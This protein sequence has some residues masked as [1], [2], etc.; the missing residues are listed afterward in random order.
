MSKQLELK[1][2][3]QQIESLPTF[4]SL[5][6]MQGLSVVLAQINAATLSIEQR[7]SLLTCVD[8]VVEGL[9]SFYQEAIRHHAFPLPVKPRAL[10]ATFQSLLGDAIS[11][12]KKLIQELIQRYDEDIPEDILHE[13]ILRSVNYLSQ[14]ALQSYAVY[15]PVPNTVWQDLHRLF[16][17]SEQKQLLTKRVEHLSD[18]SVSGAYARV[19]LMELADPGH[20]MQ[21]E[22]YQAY[23]YLR[24]WALAVRFEHP[25]E[26]PPVPLNELIINRFFCDLGSDSPPD[27][28]IEEI[29]RIPADARLLRLDEL[30][31]IV[32][33]RI[34]SLAEATER[35]LT[36]RLETELLERLLAAWKQR[37][38]RCQLRQIR[39]GITVKVI[40]GLSACHY[41]FSGYEPFEPEQVEVSLHG[42]SY[43]R[44]DSLSLVE[45]DEQPWLQSDAEAK[46]KSGVI[47]PRSLGFDLENTEND[48]WKKANI[49][50]SKQET[51][52]ERSI[53]Q[54]SHGRVH[55][56]SLVNTSSGGEG[57]ESVSG[58]DVRL[59]VGEL[60]AAFPYDNDDD[61]PKLHV[62]RWIRCE[63]GEKLS[64]GLR[65]IEGDCKPVA[66]R[67]IDSQARYLEYARAFL[68]GDES[69]L[70][71]P[72]G[73]Y[74]TN[75]ILVVNDG[76]Q[77][78]LFSLYSL[79]EHTRVFSR[80]G[81]K[82]IASTEQNASSITASL[83]QL[84]AKGY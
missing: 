65:R 71:V 52:L 12:H 37:L 20:L 30:Q 11:A 61:E 4:D 27:Y 66:V 58:T 79:L 50:P 70:I 76:E 68:L 72:A 19:L 75:S 77:L 17:Y 63:S 47:K 14:R 34:K 40:V 16:A 38:P 8:G 21:G 59:R 32:S 78:Q 53:E 55:K 6:R 26:L 44:K 36:Q 64:I 24:K 73:Q 46:L 42:D 2:I 18:L 13:S 41:F 28:G 62:A 57:L 10:S 51:E 35:T 5:E 25:D 81:I 7:I 48:V 39:R 43:S 84:L 23:E 33:D 15:E 60:L 22:I 1:K 9:F 69:A 29:A 80:F 31:K 45:V 83:D 67:A 74:E 54:Q 82:I 56:F 49:A 3:Q